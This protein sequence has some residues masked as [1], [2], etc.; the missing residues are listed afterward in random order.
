MPLFSGPSLFK[1]RLSADRPWRHFWNQV[2][3]P[4]PMERI[5]KMDADWV[6]FS[7]FIYVRAVRMGEIL[8]APVSFG[9]SFCRQAGSA[10][11]PGILRSPCDLR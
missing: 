1:N 8:D 11:P 9:H 10:E 7:R 6:P 3:Q 5:G 2:D 4:A